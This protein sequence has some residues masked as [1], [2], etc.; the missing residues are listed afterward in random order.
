LLKIIKVQNSRKFGQDFISN[1][2]FP[3]NATARS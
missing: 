3:M 2:H 1:S